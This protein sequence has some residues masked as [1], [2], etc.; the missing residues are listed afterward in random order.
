MRHLKIL[1]VVAALSLLTQ[2][3][4]SYSLYKKGNYYQAV[5]E[6]VK[7]LRSKPNNEKAQTALR[8]A[9]PLA[10]QTA[11]RTIKNLSYSTNAQKHYAIVQQYENLNR[12]ATEIHRCPKAY[13][14]IP[15]P[16]EYISELRAAKYDAAEDFYQ[17]GKSYLKN[18]D[19]QQSRTALSYFVQANNFVSCY[20][21]V[22][23]MISLAR[24]YSTLR[25]VVQKPVTNRS[26][27]ISADFFFDN[28]MN[29]LRRVTRGKMVEF[30]S[31]QEAQNARIA[32][33]HQIITLDF[34][35][36]SVGNSKESS[37]TIDCKK[38]SVFVGYSEV[39]G[40]K[41]PAYATVKATFT[42]YTV[43]ILS[44]G[45]L[46]VKV[47]D[48]NSR[49]T[50]RQQQ[51]S[52]NYRWVTEWATFKGDDRALTD[53]QKALCNHRREIPPP[54]QTLFVE[55]TKPIFTKTV[56]YLNSYYRQF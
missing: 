32:T 22:E 20:R 16:T 41:Y 1:F 53:R 37:K 50:L 54:P 44:G 9:Y 52:G 25:V 49:K 24:F 31:E 29:E 4:S 36:F 14:I 28:L 45:V 56:E 39:N 12:M 15:N 18:G 38:D 21:D 51:L 27:Q 40:Q 47:A 33:P 48:F 2:C 10:R 13:Q 19:V 17:L 26:Y 43:E 23:E 7:R 8:L 46:N 6:S 34:L 42:T 5:I 11:E 55:F 3:V 35:D 30:Y